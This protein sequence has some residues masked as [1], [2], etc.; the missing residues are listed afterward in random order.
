MQVMMIFA[1]HFD[2]VVPKK[3]V[4][5]NKTNS[6]KNLEISH[7]PTSV[8]TSPITEMMTNIQ[9]DLVDLASSWF[10]TA[11]NTNFT[12]STQFTSI[13]VTKPHAVAS[14]NAASVHQ[15]FDKG[16]NGS[17]TPSNNQKTI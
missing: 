11:R 17:N 7:T 13:P 2:Q 12:D 8:N 5:P 9:K 3:S 4:F 15:L 6:G 14:H 16:I 1:T 10:R